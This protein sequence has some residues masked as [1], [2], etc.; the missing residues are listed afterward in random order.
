MDG[1]SV[2][3][4]TFDHFLNNLSKVLQRCEDINSVMIWEKCHCMVQ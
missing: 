4:T 3:D 2:Y 1:F